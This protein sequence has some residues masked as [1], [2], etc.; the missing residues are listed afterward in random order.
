MKIFIDPGHGGGSIGAVYKGRKEKDDTLALSLEIKRQLSA[1][2]GVE[3]RLAREAD[4]ALSISERVKAAN[5]WGA[6]FYLSVHRNA[7]SPNKAEGAEVWCYSKIKAG[8]ATYTKAEKI[9]AY[10]CE[11]TGFVNRGVKLGAPNYNDFGVNRL[12]KM[13][14]CLL[15]A[16]F[17]DSDKD[18]GIFD[19]EF[20]EMA[21][22]IARGLL[23]AVGYTGEKK[24]LLGDVNGDGSV[25]SSDARLILRAAVGLENVPYEEGDIDK[26]GK[27]TSADARE[28]LRRA[29]DKND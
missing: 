25:D 17:I 11:N 16:G 26:D 6:D 23:E 15:E 7:V 27:I 9:L 14:S 2:E 10:M 13:H 8:G 1:F 3:V 24:K 28:A 19:R 4:T 29:V 12:T 18:N 20:E 5:L 22:G 21:E